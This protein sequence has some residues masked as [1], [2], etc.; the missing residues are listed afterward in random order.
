MNTRYS[1]N[2]KNCGTCNFWAGQRQLASARTLVEIPD[3]ATGDCNLAKPP[4]RNKLHNGTCPKWQVFAQFKDSQKITEKQSG[5]KSSGSKGSLPYPLMIALI[6]LVAII[7][8]IVKNKDYFLGIALVV[9]P[10]TVTCFL[11]Y[12]FA[13]KPKVKI[14]IIASLGVILSLAAVFNTHQKREN[15]KEQIRQTAQNIKTVTVNGGYKPTFGTGN[16]FSS[17]YG[18]IAVRGSLE[19]SAYEDY[20]SISK[21]KLDR[22]SV[23]RYYQKTSNTNAPKSTNIGLSGI[24]FLTENGSNYTLDDVTVVSNINEDSWILNNAD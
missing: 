15:V 2:I 6:A 8:F 10:C 1:S 4:I 13:K 5:K 21:I 9:I 24:F 22:D 14:I 12:K 18:K 23:N 19:Y 7:S 16:S 20:F 3:G 11:I 17:E